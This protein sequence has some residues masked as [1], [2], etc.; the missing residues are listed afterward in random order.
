MIKYKTNVPVPKTR[1]LEA[2]TI[3]AGIAE[4][5][6]PIMGTIS[7]TPAKRQGIEQ[8]GCL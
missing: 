7:K 6:G 3:N 4:R 5:I 1:E 8:K 2:A